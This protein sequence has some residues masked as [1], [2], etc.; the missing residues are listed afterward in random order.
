MT[1]DS[2]NYRIEEAERIGSH[3]VVRVRYPSCSRC[4]FDGNKVMVF[5]NVTEMQVIRW[6]RID[7]HFRPPEK[8]PLDTEAP[9]PAARFPATREGWADA[10]S[11]ARGK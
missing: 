2:S 6:R 10:V 8:S 11:Y 9:S 7:P 5:L 3:L 4:E 1:P